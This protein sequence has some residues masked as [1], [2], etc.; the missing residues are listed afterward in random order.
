MYQSYLKVQ[1]IRLIKPSVCSVSHK[2]L[3]TIS[4]VMGLSPYDDKRYIK[5]NGTDSLAY[6]HYLL[7][8]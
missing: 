5:D 2:V 7:R 3:T 1:Y 6:H 4:E 8:E